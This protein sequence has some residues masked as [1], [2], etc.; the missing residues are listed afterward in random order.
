[1]A[2]SMD[3]KYYGLGESLVTARLPVVVRPRSVVCEKYIYF[4]SSKVLKLWRSL[5]YERDRSKPNRKKY[6]CEVRIW[7]QQKSVIT[8]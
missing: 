6:H 3:A 8:G 2:A 7:L 4:K 5:C 1:M